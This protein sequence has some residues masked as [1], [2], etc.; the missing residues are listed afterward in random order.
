M[1]AG[2]MLIRAPWWPHYQAGFF[3]FFAG[4]GVARAEST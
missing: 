4:P 1:L 3:F 2:M